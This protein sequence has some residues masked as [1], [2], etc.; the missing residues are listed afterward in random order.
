MSRRAARHA[1]ATTT[2]EQLLTELPLPRE[3]GSGEESLNQLD[4]MVEDL[5]VEDP[6]YA[7]SLQAVVDA[8]ASQRETGLPGALFYGLSSQGIMVDPHSLLD[9]TRGEMID[10]VQSAVDDDTVP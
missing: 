4:A 5:A 1:A 3:D 6:E 10:A 7:A 9:H 2:Y 8:E